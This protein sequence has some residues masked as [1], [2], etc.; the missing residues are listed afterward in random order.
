MA[1]AEMLG[2]TNVGESS[3]CCYLEA[4]YLQI[5]TNWALPKQLVRPLQLFLDPPTMKCQ[6]KL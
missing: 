6:H 5:A 4:I 2:N 1:A 3:S